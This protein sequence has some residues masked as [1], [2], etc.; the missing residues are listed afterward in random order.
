MKKRSASGN[1]LAD[2][3]PV[4]TWTV[5]QLNSL[6]RTL[7][8]DAFPKLRVTGEL[9]SWK[10]AA[11]GHCYFTLRDE[12][13]QL[14][15]VM[16]REDAWR[17]PMEP[18]LGMKLRAHGGLTLYEA[19][20]RYQMVVRRLEAEEGEGLWRLAFDRLRSQLH[21]EGL[22][23]PRRKRDI[24]PFPESVGI[25][26]SLGGAALHDILTVLRRRA[27][28]TR[29]VAR[30]ARVQGEGASQALAEAVGVLDRSGLVDVIVVGRGGGSVEDLWAFN[31]EPLARAIAEASLPVISAVGHEVDVTI[32]DLV[33]DLRAPTPSA[34][35]EMVAP[36][37]G[38]VAQRLR[39]LGRRISST[40]RS[41]FRHGRERVA[42]GRER[43]TG[44]VRGVAAPRALRVERLGE[45]LSGAMR[46]RLDGRKRRLMRSSGKMEAL[47]PL[48]TLR[49]G[50]AVALSEGGGVLRRAA[51]FRS[52]ARFSLRLF[53]GRVECEVLDSMGEKRVGG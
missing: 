24:P 21:A 3:P 26:T 32:S 52:G 37:A 34:A 31:E 20:G 10:R 45:R 48:S 49:R 14:D 19:R 12:D 13:A 41:V 43:L 15:C 25:V 17:L 33:A 28:W 44:G 4:P 38:A 11:S 35:G 22:L 8:E 27:P 16:W 6:I 29:V 53:D 30:G 1:V 39:A 46:S 36:D 40:S 2:A 47:S 51:D 9:G 42:R 5:S 50:Y 18:K 23:D 7:M